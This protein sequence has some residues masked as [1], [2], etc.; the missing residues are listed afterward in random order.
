[1]SASFLSM[2]RL[3]SR[4]RLRALHAA[5]HDFPRFYEVEIG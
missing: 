4:G 3:A 1:M 5:T 2:E